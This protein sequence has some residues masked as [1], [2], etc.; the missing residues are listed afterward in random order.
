MTDE[1]QRHILAMLEAGKISAEEA[2]RLMQALDGNPARDEEPAFEA[3]ADP[4][5]GFEADDGLAATAAKVRGFWRIPLWIGVGVTVMGGLL[6]YWAMQASGLGFWFYCAWLPFLLGVL[7]IALSAAS[8]TSRW[9]FVRVEQAPGE[10][11]HKIVFGFPLPLRATA[12]GL[13][14]FGHMIHGLDATSVDEVL[15]ALAET[16]SGDAPLIID[17][18]DDEDGE[19]VQVLIG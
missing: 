15:Q 11:P 3:E 12:W 4:S 13:R 14:N 8:R 1:A 7:V 2:A 6:M 10:S 18:H 19:H 16:P 17:V 9:L 5:S